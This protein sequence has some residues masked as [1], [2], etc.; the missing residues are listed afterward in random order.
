MDNTTLLFV[1]NGLVGSLM[2]LPQI[3]TIIQNQRSKFRNGGTRD[4]SLITW[5]I[6]LITSA[7][8]TYYGF[9]I[10]AVPNIVAGFVM[11][12]LDVVLIGYVMWLRFRET[13]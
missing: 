8:W 7:V 5:V 2:P 10:G 11:C 3:I 9:H 1:V 4:V 13:W 6:S 12:F